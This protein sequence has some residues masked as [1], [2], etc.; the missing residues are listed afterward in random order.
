L[1]NASGKLEFTLISDGPTVRFDE[2]KSEVRIILNLFL[3]STFCVGIFWVSSALHPSD[4]LLYSYEAEYTFFKKTENKLTRSFIF[5]FGYKDG[6]L[7]LSNS[8]LGDYVDRIYTIEL[9]I[10]N[11]EDTD[12]CFIL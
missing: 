6:V 7:S 3:F 8:K 1:S 10:E 11:I 5:T 4:M 12:V 2:F 9:D